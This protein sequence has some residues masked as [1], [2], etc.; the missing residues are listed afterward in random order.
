MVEIELAVDQV[1]YF[2]REAA[3]PDM[4][5]DRLLRELLGRIAEDRIAGT[6]LD[7]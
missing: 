7:D 6:V 2:R 3:L 4:P 5:L 1:R